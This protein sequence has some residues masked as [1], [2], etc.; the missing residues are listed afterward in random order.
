KTESV[1]NQDKSLA[2]V[3]VGYGVGQF[4]VNDYQGSDAVLDVELN[5]LSAELVRQYQQQVQ[6][7]NGQAPEQMMAKMKEFVQ[8]HLLAQL[9]ANPE[10]NITRLSAT[11]PEG[12]FNSHAHISFS[13]IDTLPDNLQ[14]ASFWL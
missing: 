2:D 9:K 14:D 6:T 5:N 11:L 13:D 7:L 10:F 1:V 4:N 12:K 8:E 3:K